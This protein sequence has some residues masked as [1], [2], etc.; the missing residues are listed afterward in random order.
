LLLFTAVLLTAFFPWGEQ[1][2]AGQF[3]RTL[4]PSG[5]VTLV[6]K[7]GSGSVAVHHGSGSSVE[8]HATISSR[9]AEADAGRIRE[10]EQNPPIHQDGDRIQIGPLP[11]EWAR[12]LS[13]A[14]DITTPAT[15]SAN[16][17]TGSGEIH[18]DG[19]QGA[20]ELDTGS[21]GI[22]TSDV[23][24]SLHASTGSGDITVHTVQGNAHLQTGSG[25][26][27]ANGL[28]GSATLSTG[29]GDI[30]V[31]GGQAV[32]AETGSGSIHATG[33]HGDF[34]A[35]TGSGDVSAQGVLPDGHHWDLYTGSGS[36][37]LSLPSGT[38]AR[39]DLQTD[40]GSIHSDLPLQVQGKLN[41]HHMTGTLGGGNATAWL[42]VRTG[43]GDIR[44]H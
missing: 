12:G 34:R 36:I 4:H 18:V 5:V 13:I 26:I 33:V 6:V 17:S 10:I 30:I 43:S 11:H 42:I 28:T 14:Y 20:V 3:T 29:S 24:Q 38:H 19:L 21:G 35:R 25:S 41:S 7:T 44:I 27:H 8:I 39:A 23:G 22:E 9:H 15:S 37:D 16:V 31:T 32:R 2:Q 1:K 40:S